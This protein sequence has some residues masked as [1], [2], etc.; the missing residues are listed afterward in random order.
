MWERAAD[1]DMVLGAGCSVVCQPV[2]LMTAAWNLPTV[3]FSCASG[4]LSDKDT[5]PTFTRSVGP[6]VGFAP[7]FNA[8]LDVFG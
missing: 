1:L 8:I 2:S 6:Y 7:M 5:Y 3:S 4:S